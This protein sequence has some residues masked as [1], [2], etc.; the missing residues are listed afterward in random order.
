[1]SPDATRW[2]LFSGLRRI[3]DNRGEAARKILDEVAQALAA[4]EYAVG[5]KGVLAE[6]EHAAIALVT[7]PPKPEEKKTPP[8][9]LRQVIG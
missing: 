6:K 3:T 7:T 2:E 9:D 1:M 5:L 4:D 8:E